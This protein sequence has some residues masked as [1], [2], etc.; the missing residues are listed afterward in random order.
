M[1]P[2]TRTAPL[3]CLIVRIIETIDLSHRTLLLQKL[4]FFFCHKLRTLSITVKRRLAW[5]LRLR[6]DDIMT[7]TNREV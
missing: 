3:P 2:V 7:R 5:P 1:A 4:T 6:K